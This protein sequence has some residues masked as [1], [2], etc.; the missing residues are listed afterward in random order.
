MIWP[1]ELK[2]W[3]DMIQ[4]ASTVLAII[5]GGYWSFRIYRQKRQRFPRA[6]IEHQIL[7]CT[8]NQ[9]KILLRVTTRI[10][11]IGDSLISLGHASTTLEK[12][13]PLDFKIQ[14][15]LEKDDGLVI[16]KET[17]IKWSNEPFR[18]LSVDWPKGRVQLEPGERDHFYFDFILEHHIQIVLITSYFRNIQKYRFRRSILTWLA[19]NLDTRRGLFRNL[20]NSLHDIGWEIATLYDLNQSTL[21]NPHATTNTI[22]S[23]SSDTSQ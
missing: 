6:K 3:L 2:D 20:R 8:L 4:A 15:R 18:K 23:I 17:S 13:I 11:N 1:T 16:Q 9:E 7:Q 14:A 10:E 19:N 12:V 5:I 21:A 22:A